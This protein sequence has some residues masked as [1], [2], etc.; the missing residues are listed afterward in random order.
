MNV[1]IEEQLHELLNARREVEA[2]GRKLTLF[3]ER[4]PIA[5]L[6]FDSNATILEMNPAA[7][8]LF[9]YA[10]AE[11][12]GRNGLQMLFP[13]DEFGVNETWWRDFVP[14]TIRSR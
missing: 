10:L 3:A 7:E 8:N 12:I 14:A 13:V 11:L 1:Q 4:A 9:G 6:E 5:V 2:S